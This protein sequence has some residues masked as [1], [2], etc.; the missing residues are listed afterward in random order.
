MGTVPYPTKE[1]VKM[2]SLMTRSPYASFDTFLDTFLDER[3]NRGNVKTTMTMSPRAQ[4]TE[5]DR[6]YSIAVEM[7]GLSRSDIEVSL[8]NDYLTVFGER[9]V[10]GKKS[11]YS[12]SWSLGENVTQEGISARYDAGILYVEVPVQKTMKRVI[13][14]E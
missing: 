5:S 3:S 8:E 9:E 10:N 1:K 6:G 11:T 13:S 12:R 14:V 2:F 7:P 4:I